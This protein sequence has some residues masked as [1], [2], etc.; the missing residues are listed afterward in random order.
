MMDLDPA[1]IR[2]GETGEGM[3]KQLLAAG[4]I[5]PEPATTAQ[6]LYDRFADKTRCPLCGLESTTSAITRHI[7]GAH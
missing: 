3:F 5:I 4:V 1:E 2:H 7:R 6:H